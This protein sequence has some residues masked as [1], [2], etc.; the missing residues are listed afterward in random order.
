MFFIQ[1][2][3]VSYYDYRPFRSALLNKVIGNSSKILGFLGKSFLP[4]YFNLCP[5]TILEIEKRSLVIATMTSF[6]ARI[7]TLWIV[8][9][10]LIRQKLQPKQ[11]WLYLSERQFPKHELPKS[12]KKY[13]NCDF[14]KIIWVKE[15]YRSYKKFWYFIKDHP[16][17]SFITLD[18]DI[19]YQ[20]N[21]ICL[22]VEG[23]VKYTGYVVACYC[24]RIKYNT[25]GSCKPYRT[26]DKQT[27][28]GDAGNDIFFGSGGGTL[29]PVGSLNGSNADYETIKHVCPSADDIWLNAFVRYNGF[30]TVCV[31]NRRWSFVS[32]PIEYNTSLSSQNL[33]ENLNDKQIKNIILFFKKKGFNPFIKSK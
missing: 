9:E 29:F 15:D 1:D 18:D 5:G 31:K 16:N 17:E 21:T 8:M 6:P 19:I 3:F 27:K 10:S 2:L 20:S 33:G 12:L 25:D 24:Y 7:G 28:R 32:V 14:L 23:Q 30:K 26:W 4:W 22:L 13:I 11:V